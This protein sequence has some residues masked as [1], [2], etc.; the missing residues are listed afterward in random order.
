[1]VTCYGIWGP[2]EELPAR[3][4]RDLS[5]GVTWKVGRRLKK[6]HQ[7]GSGC[8]EIFSSD[9]FRCVS[10]Y[11][12]VTCNYGCWMIEVV[13]QL[14]HRRLR[15]AR[16]LGVKMTD[17]QTTTAEEYQITNTVQVY[18]GHRLAKQRILQCILIMFSCILQHFGDCLEEES[19]HGKWLIW[20]KSYPHRKISCIK[21][22]R[23]RKSCRRP[24]A[25][26]D[27]RNLYISPS[28]LTSGISPA[29]ARSRNTSTIPT[30]LIPCNRTLATEQ[31]QLRQLFFSSALGVAS[32]RKF[33]FIFTSIFGHRSELFSSPVAVQ[34][35][36]RCRETQLEWKIVEESKMI[37]DGFC[38]LVRLLISWILA[39]NSGSL[40][41]KS[42]KVSKSLGIAQINGHEPWKQLHFQTE[43]LVFKFWTL[44]KFSKYFGNTQWQIS[45]RLQSSE[46]S[47]IHRVTRFIPGPGWRLYATAWTAVPPVQVAFFQTLSQSF[48]THFRNPKSTLGKLF[49][50][51]AK[52]NQKAEKDTRTTS[53][54]WNHHKSTILTICMLQ[55]F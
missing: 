42:E 40:D 43:Q 52:A 55:L 7:T 30:S 23:G 36:N 20:L 1:M 10:M 4:A 51:T 28:H 13:I 29:L 9:V 12:D 16:A 22:P 35:P 11:F 27:S 8:R 37:K 2:P 15:T 6:L 26:S 19:R 17:L 24:T 32:P 34:L 41:Q 46:I 21:V 47:W 25:S 45:I 3:P 49:P 31:F 54:N 48:P 50:W 44:S 14:V 18:L 33:C 39:L 38:I 53:D 5:V